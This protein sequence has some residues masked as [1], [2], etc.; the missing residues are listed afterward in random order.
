MN[1]AGKIKLFITIAFF[2]LASSNSYILYAQC[3]QN[4]IVVAQYELRDINGNPFTITD[5]YQIGQAVT[6]QL[7]VTLITN[8]TNGYNLFM[9]YDIHKNGTLSQAQLKDCIFQGEKILQGV[10]VYV[11]DFTWNW[12]DKIDVKNIFM[13]WTTGNV[14]ANPPPCE[15]SL[16]NNINAQCYTNPE[17]FTA[18]LPLYPNFSYAPALCNTRI[19]FT[20]STTGGTAPYNYTYFWNFDGQGSSTLKDPIFDFVIPGTYNVSLTAN[21]GTTTTT[22][23]KTIVVP[24]NF[25]I[26][27]TIVPTKINNSSGIIY[28]NVSGGT[29]PYTYNWTGPNGFTSTSKDIFNLSDGN[30]TLTVTDYNGCHQTVS[31]VMDVA[32]VL[33]SELISFEIYFNNNSTEIIIDWEVSKE[34]SESTYE[35]ERSNSNVEEF[36][37]IGSIET[38]T[39]SSE[40]VKYSFIDKNVP[41]YINLF[42]YRIKKISGSAISYSPV[43]LAKREAPFA[44]KNQWQ[45]FPN[46]SNQEDVFIRTLSENNNVSSP[47]RLRI[48]NS[49]NCFYSQEIELRSSV[50][51]NLN[52]IFGELPP[53]LTIVEI[54]WDSK[55]EIIKILRGS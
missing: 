29:A 23:T 55:T 14:P 49:G 32:S 30:Y 12:G 21:D 19:Q 2:I 27:V 42:Y 44:S 10:P 48:M 38:F 26:N 24:E 52:E 1:F 37:T 47:I 15:E 5:N 20:N 6:G 17:G 40:P 39:K 8:S 50:M 54:Q 28:T 31:Y 34:L 43:K 33:S 11:R 25:E 16:K 51:I 46:P 45:A 35:I 7:F 41:V 13:Y 3:S 22:F 9:T 4:N 18:A 53:G 36:V